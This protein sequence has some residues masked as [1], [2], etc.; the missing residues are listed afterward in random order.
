MYQER[1]FIKNKKKNLGLEQIKKKK[2]FFTSESIKI[3]K[4]IIK[5]NKEATNVVAVFKMFQKHKK[6]ILRE[7][8]FCREENRRYNSRN[9]RSLL[10][11]NV[12]KF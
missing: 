1:V 12:T 2:Y 7:R 3:T 4:N 9:I 10:P 8:Y 11:F 6:N 5:K